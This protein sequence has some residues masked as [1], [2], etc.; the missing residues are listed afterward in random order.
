MNQPKKWTE[1]YPYGTKEGDE[2][3]K[4][5]RALARNP[6]YDYRS[7]A[8]IA[9]ETK[10]SRVRVEEIIDKYATKYNP[11]LIYVHP[12]NEENWGYWE[13]CP[14]RLIK[15]NRGVSDKDKDNRIGKHMS[16]NCSAVSVDDATS[17]ITCDAT[18][19]STDFPL[20]FFSPPTESKTVT[21][22]LT[23]IVH[24]VEMTWDELQ[25]QIRPDLLGY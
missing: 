22:P 9:K 25:A 4:V 12:T 7:I 19:K 10:L 14:D 3:A 23:G 20:D 11:P 2:E 8:A 21:C 17:V 24:T 6:K 1:V 5:F 16:G 15:D 18:S 13:R